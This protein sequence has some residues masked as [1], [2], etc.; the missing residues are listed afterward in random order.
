MGSGETS[1]SFVVILVV[2]GGACWVSHGSHCF[3]VCLSFSLSVEVSV[4]LCPVSV[5]WQLLS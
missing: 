4:S 2:I 1:V 5:C 3:L